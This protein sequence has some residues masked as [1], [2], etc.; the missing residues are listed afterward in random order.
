MSEQL[1]N[2]ASVN[3]FIDF[4]KNSPTAFHAVN[5]ICEKLE[6]AGFSRVNENDNVRLTAGRWYITRNLSSVIAFEIPEGAADHFQIV[7]SHTDSPVFK[8]K[9]KCEQQALGAY[10]RLNVEPYG[11]MIMSTWLDRPLGIAGRVFIRQGEKIT[12]KLVDLDRDACVI[13]N[14]PIHFNRECNSGYAFKPQTDLLPLF[15]DN[16]DAGKL[17]QQIAAKAGCSVDE[18]AGSDLF[19]Y[20]R[21]PGTVWGAEDQFFSC[22]RIDDLEC[23]YTSVEAIISSHPKKQVNICAVFDN[24]EVGSRSKQGADSTFLQDTM[25]RIAEDLGNSLSKARA[26]ISASFMLSADNAHAL[27]P[28]HPEK[29]DADNRTYMNRGVVIKHNANQKYTTDGASSAVFETICANAGVPVQHFHNHS[30]LPGGS[31]LGNIANAHVSMNTVDIGAAQLAMHSSYESAGCADVK[32]MADAM[33]AFYAACVKTDADG[34]F[35]IE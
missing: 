5:A 10:C 32:H 6:K 3:G 28:N 2:V 24:E 25:L 27:H 18:I 23:A 8:L 20:G 30:D 1:S 14:M 15:G 19:L 16:T 31:T 33:E 7:A 12:A 11:G 9:Q 34:C 21:V 35:T 22:G 4:V 13:P 29:F 26:M 17:N